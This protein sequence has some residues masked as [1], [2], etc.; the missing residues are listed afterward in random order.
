[1]KKL[2]GGFYEIGVFKSSGERRQRQRVFG[3][4]PFSVLVKLKKF[5]PEYIGATCMTPDSSHILN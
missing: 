5:P 2:K 3:G 1:M 4:E